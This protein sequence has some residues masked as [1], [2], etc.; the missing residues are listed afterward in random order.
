MNL[1]KRFAT[2]LDRISFAS[3]VARQRAA[4]AERAEQRDSST[5]IADRLKLIVVRFEA[6]ADEMEAALN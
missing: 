6:L 2:A 3:S 5:D 4:E 1:H